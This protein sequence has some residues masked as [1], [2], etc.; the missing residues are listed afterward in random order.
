MPDPLAQAPER[1]AGLADSEDVSGRPRAGV[2]LVD[3]DGQWHAVSPAL[4]GML[5]EEAANLVGSAAHRRLFAAQAGLIDACLQERADERPAGAPMAVDLPASG[6]MRRLAA[7]IEPL[8]GRA[9]MAPMF[10]LRLEEDAANGHPREVLELAHRQQEH[11]A[12]GFSHDL[13]GSLRSIEGF[14]AQLARQPLDADGR[15]HL[16]RIHVAAGQ[17]GRLVDS[18]VQLSRATTATYDEAPVDLSLLAV[19]VAAELQDADPQRAAEVS[20]QP[21]LATRGDE[22]H[23]R[24]L[25]QQLLHNAWKFARAGE[26]VRI[27]V[28]ATQHSDAGRMWLTVRDQ[29]RGFDMEYADRILLPFKRLHGPE[30]GGGH[31]LGL[32]IADTVARRHGGCI[33][34]AS[35]TGGGSVFSVELPAVAGSDA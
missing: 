14:A 23:L 28:T 24:I 35:S 11:L 9:G 15:A 5:G 4:C 19:W 18:L 30:D 29:G 27:D 22:R 20:V 26:P 34:M 16:H 13:R 7:T 2:A 31:G 10:L 6:G 21:G 12:F 25:L 3:G 17:A 32:A 8:A 1:V 33:R